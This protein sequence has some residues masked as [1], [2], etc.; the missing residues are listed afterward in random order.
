M[1]AQDFIELAFKGTVVCLKGSLIGFVVFLVAGRFT[2]KTN[3]RRL[4]RATVIASV[5]C[6]VIS[7][8]SLAALAVL[9]YLGICVATGSKSIP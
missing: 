5:T 1:N 2:L 8:M 6:L 3:L 4:D 9:F 7:V